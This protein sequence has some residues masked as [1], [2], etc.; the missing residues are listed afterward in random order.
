MFE[1]IKKGIGYGVGFYLG[2]GFS[3]AIS[4]A[5]HKVR[6]EDEKTEDEK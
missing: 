6:N 5:I 2:A 3:V 1:Y 4:E